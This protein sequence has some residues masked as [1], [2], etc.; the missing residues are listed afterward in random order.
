MLHYTCTSLSES[1]LLLSFG[2]EIN[3]PLYDEVMKAKEL[4]EQNPFD[5]FIE[6]VPA[7]NSLAVY[8]NPMQVEAKEQSIAYAVEQIIYHTLNNPVIQ[9]SIDPIIQQSHN[10]I[11]I[12]VCYHETFGIDL[13]EL[14]EILNRSVEEIIQLHSSK[15]YKVFM[16]GF[17]PGF[18]YM[19]I[20]DERIIAKRKSSPRIKVE[21]GS[22]AIVGNQ[23][24]I[25]S[26]NTPGGWN[27]IGRTPVKLF[28]VTKEN[29]FLLKAGD[30]VKFEVI[31]KDEFEH[32]A[33]S[34]VPVGREIR[35]GI[36]PT[37]ASDDN[38]Q[39]IHIEQ[40]GFLTTIQD[41][42]RI[43]Y[44]QYGVSKGGAM[45]TYSMQLANLLVGNDL[46]APVLELTQSPHQFKFLQDTFV[47][48]AGGGLQPQINGTELSFL[49]VHFIKAGAVLELKK[50]IPGFRLYMTVAGGFAG[51]KF[52]N[53]C[54]TDLLV[55]AGG[56]EGRPLKKGDTLSLQKKL[57]DFQKNL[58]AVFQSGA[59]IKFNLETVNFQKNSIRVMKGAEWDFLTEEAKEKIHSTS[60]SI[61]PQS[62]RMG[63]RLKGESITSNEA[64]DIISSP[65]TQG[66]V[67]LTSS[68]E[69]I[70]LM[71]DA[72]TVG[73]YP[74]VLQVIAADLPL[75][76]QKKPGDAIQFEMVSLQQA[77]EALK[78]K[79]ATI[80]TIQCAIQNLY[81]F[82][83]KQ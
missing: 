1:A 49:Q 2:N 75:L 51:D 48:F 31:A 68:G 30:E 15:T 20:V 70:I 55:K 46:S 57:T 27:I 17:T 63:Y 5:G 80:Q 33:T 4:L 69:L 74:R 9:Q 77:E 41:A 61:S 79:A 18:P 35:N 81:G 3:L 12:P 22:V 44:L 64:C 8:Y 53:S 42:G 43:N 21:A 11:I 10:I 45:D 37:R 76:A 56:F 54:S 28:D 38:N 26:L 50:Q 40:C 39:I 73:G 13:Q 29:P 78:N 71:A 24:G 62:S 83:N 67:Q 52:L 60:F 66:T 32:Y 14:S 16:T 36:R 82:K 65:V 47:A 34:D 19:G 6:T 58:Y 59:A 23:T 25:Y 7:Y 72:Q